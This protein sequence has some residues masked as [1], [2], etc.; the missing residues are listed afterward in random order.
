MENVITVSSLTKSFKKK[1][2]LNN[3]SFS[4]GRGS[5]VGLLGANGAGKTTLIQTLLG[6]IKADKGSCKIFDDV[7]PNLSAK[8]KHKIG[9]VSQEPELIN[10]MKVG[11]MT[12]YI[13]SFYTHWNSDLVESLLHEWSIDKKQLVEKLS[14][15]QKQKLSIVLALGHEPELLIL[16]EPVASLDP[17]SRRSFIK[18]LI[19]MNLDQQRTILFSTH[20][21]SDL[22]R[23]AAEV[24][25]L[26][27]G[28]LYYHGDIDE[29]KEKIVKLH[30]HARQSLPPS[31]KIKGSIY[32]KVSNN[33]A[34]VLVEDLSEIELDKLASELDA[35]IR[36]ESLNLEDIFVELHS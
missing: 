23:V 36:S 24:M 2:V 31:L 1:I 25:I 26:K 20:I 22:E 3:V 7:S 4:I 17:V 13:A 12:D 30:I 34:T 21:T 27:N 35:E 29:L 18:K 6:F 19:D 14:L 32:Q 8:T 5:V 11:Q 15:G 9:Y 10:W 33:Q 16:D 28:E